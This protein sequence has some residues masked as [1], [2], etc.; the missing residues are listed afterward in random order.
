MAVFGFLPFGRFAWGQPTS[1][2]YSLSV[3]KGDLTLT[4]K[5]QTF[6]VT[7]AVAKSDLILT[8]KSE[9]FGVALAVIAGALT[10]SGQTVVQIITTTES[11]ATLTLHGNASSF[12]V[13]ESVSSAALT[14][15]WQS[16]STLIT[17]ASAKGDLTLTGEYSGLTPEIDHGT[18]TLTGQQIALTPTIP[19]V[20]GQL[21]L[22]PHDV[23][24]IAIG[25]ASGAPAGGKRKKTGFEPVKKRKPPE[26]DVPAPLPIPPIGPKPRLPAEIRAP[27]D[28]VDPALIPTSLLDLEQQVLSAQD[29]A[30][31][32]AYLRQLDQDEQDAA[33]IAEV[34]ALLD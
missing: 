15:T 29:I 13:T 6:K 23:P 27:L 7:E 32:E 4:G 2:L 18:L 11:G 1:A 3:S 30:D 19:V 17:M 24:L 8:G 5:V 16:S 10:L 25:G 31:A 12:L 26:P 28:I 14:L 9:S 21:T 33:D 22:T 34:L 20:P